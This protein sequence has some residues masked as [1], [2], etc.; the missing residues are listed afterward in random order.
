M[1]QDDREERAEMITH[2]TYFSA[3][4][5]AE[6]SAA[7]DAP[8]PDTPE[9]RRTFELA[10]KARFLVDQVLEQEEQRKRRNGKA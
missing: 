10:E 1:Q 6:I 2:T 3:A 4:G 9:R 7:L 5:M 8:P